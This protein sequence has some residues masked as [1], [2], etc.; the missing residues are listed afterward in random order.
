L[1]DAGILKASGS[2]DEDKEK[3]DEQM[4]KQTYSITIAGNTYS[5]DWLAPTGIP[6]FI[7]AECYEI[8]Q[9]EAEETTAISAVRPALRRSVRSA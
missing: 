9:T 1:A 3:Y 4:G 2:D 5:L 8:M 7:G 6:L